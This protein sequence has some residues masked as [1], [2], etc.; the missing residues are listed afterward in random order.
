MIKGKRKEGKKKGGGEEL[1]QNLIFKGEKR[2]IFPVPPIYMV[3]EKISFWK[4]G[5]GRIWFFGKIYTPGKRTF[6]S[7]TKNLVII[8]KSIEKLKY[9]TKKN[10]IL[11]LTI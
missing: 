4:R 9:S 5:G 7:K 11:V 3:G 8:Q 1:L 6:F 10:L 2:F